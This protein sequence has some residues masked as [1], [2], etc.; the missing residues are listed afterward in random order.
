MGQQEHIADIKVD[1]E[2]TRV[3]EHG[4]QSWSPSTTYS[5]GASPFR[6]RND[7][8]LVMAYRGEVPSSPGVYQGEGLLAVQPGTDAAEN[9]SL[10]VSSVS[11]RVCSGDM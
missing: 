7:S 1:R 3:Y 2:R 8:A 10:R 4:W 5:L 9:R 6:P 11:P